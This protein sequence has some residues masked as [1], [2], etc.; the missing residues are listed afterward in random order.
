MKGPHPKTAVDCGCEDE[1][2]EEYEIYR[3]DYEEYESRQPILAA[4]GEELQP[5]DH[6]YMWCTGYQHHAIVIDIDIDIDTSIVD[7]SDGSGTNDDARPSVLIAEFTNVQLAVANTLIVSSSTASG[8]VSGNG[9]TGGFRFLRETDPS[10]KWHKVKYQANP[11]E[12]I[13][14]R[15]G[16]CSA[17]CPSHPSQILMRVQ[18][19]HDCRHV[20]PEYHLLSSNCETVSVWCVTGKWET[21]Q[22]QQTMKWSQALT[23][24]MMPVAPGFGM[25][26]AGLAFWHSKQIQ[27]QWQQT[28]GRLNREFEWYSMGKK[29]K[30]IFE[31]QRSEI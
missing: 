8:A 5:G 22:Y 15:P 3:L 29:P 26:A 16:T 28:D 18:F 11:L 21:L 7:D 19:L 17:A 25:V 24:G 30:R 13:T 23:T 9:V 10:Q 4:G 1:N 14:W 27:H 6:V 20:L 31:C 12:C 2:L